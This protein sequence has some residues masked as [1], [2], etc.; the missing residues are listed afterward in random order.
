[1]KSTRIYSDLLGFT[2]MWSDVI[3]CGERLS[4][5]DRANT[6]SC[7]KNVSRSGLVGIGQDDSGLVGRPLARRPIYGWTG[8][9]TEWPQKGTKRHKGVT[10]SGKFNFGADRCR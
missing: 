10:I 8:K 3:G 4:G 5:E 7:Q 9:G 1:M 6:S 2:R